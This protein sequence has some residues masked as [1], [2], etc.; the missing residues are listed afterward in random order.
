MKYQVVL[1]LNTT[2][3]QLDMCED[4]KKL[5]SPWLSWTSKSLEY[6]LVCNPSSMH[7][8]TDQ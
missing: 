6:E 4:H 1:M 7:G 8:L 2:M 3:H 5:L